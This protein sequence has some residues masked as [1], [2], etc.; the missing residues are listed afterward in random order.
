[1]PQECTETISVGCPGIRDAPC[2]GLCFFKVCANWDDIDGS[3]NIENLTITF[4][5][6]THPRP[7]VG[8]PE[9]V[10]AAAAGCSGNFN[11]G[12]GYVEYVDAN[13][14]RHRLDNDDYTQGTVNDFQ[15]LSDDDRDKMGE[16]L[17]KGHC[18]EW[19]EADIDWYI[20]HS[21]TSMNGWDIS[22]ECQEH[23]TGSGM[24]VSGLGAAGG[25]EIR[26]F[27][28]DYTI[29]VSCHCGE[30]RNTA[31]VKVELSGP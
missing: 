2:R 22:W 31:K 11:G 9:E 12:S 21:L 23:E 26:S 14:N 17:E 27:E 30:N 20:D 18:S 28:M 16:I 5:T 4:E 3:D 15:A 29:D 8:T 13:G 25:D 10:E 6:W 1:M 19:T 24:S 7:L